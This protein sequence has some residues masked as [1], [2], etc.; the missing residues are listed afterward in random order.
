MLEAKNICKHYQPKKGVSVQAIDHVSLRFPERGMVF[1]LG[2]SGSGK[3]TLLHLLGGLDT[4][5]EGE[6]IFNGISLK[7]FRAQSFDSYRNTCVGFVFQEYNLLSDFSVGANIAIALELQGKKADDAEISR[8]L[9]EVDLDGFGDRKPDELSGGQKQRVAIARALVKNPQIILADEPTGALDAE[10][11]RQVLGTLKELS[12]EKLVILISHEREFAEQY[13]D[14][15]IEMADGKVVRDVEW[16][17]EQPE[18]STLSFRSSAIEIPCGYQLTEADRLRINEYLER[19]K[20]DATMMQSDDM[21]GFQQTDETRIPVPQGEPPELIHSKMPLRRAFHIGCSNLGHKRFRLGM[22]IFLSVVAFSMFALADTFH[23]YEH[24]RV[25]TDSLLQYETEYVTVHKAE[26]CSDSLS[27]Y[28]STEG[29]LLSDDDLTVIRNDTGVAMTG[30]YLPPSSNLSYSMHFDYTAL[31]SNNTVLMSEFCGFTEISEEVLAE[32]GCSLIAGSIPDGNKNEIALSL[33]ACEPFLKAGYAPVI[34]DDNGFVSY[35][36]WATNE[37]DGK[38]LRVV[39]YSKITAPQDMI[40]KTLLLDKVSYTVTGVVDTHEDTE[41]YQPQRDAEGVVSKSQ[42][43]LNEMLLA[44]F[45]SAVHHSLTG[46]AM[47]GSGKVTQMIEAAPNTYAPRTG[48]GFSMQSNIYADR[49]YAVKPTHYTTMSR[50]ASDEILWLDGERESLAENEVILSVDSIQCVLRNGSTLSLFSA[51]EAITLEK[52]Q[53]LTADIGTLNGSVEIGGV[54]AQR[55]EAVQIVGFIQA[56]SVYHGTMICADAIVKQLIDVDGKYV[57]AFGAMPDSRD[58]LEEFVRYCYRD[59]VDVQMRYELNHA[60][61]YELDKID[62]VFQLFY[63]VLSVFSGGFAIFAMLLM[64]GFITRSIQHRE[65]EIGILRAIGARSNDVLHIFLSET[66]MIAL[67]N[68]LLSMS[69]CSGC[70]M[71]VN[72]AVRRYYHIV[73]QLLHFDTRQV[74]LLLAVSMLS[75]WLAGFVP[76]SS[77]AAKK[78]LDAICGR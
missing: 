52:L 72:Y 30:I 68:F 37:E 46:C 45:D 23:S 75:A 41:R 59:D 39:D 44:E 73:V 6:I 60:V 43:L 76:A 25:C 50:I 21:R 48:C 16:I 2:K 35:N 7:K 62:T 24:I 17:T 64:A 38:S 77:I 42:R 13:A 11:G 58:A 3:S 34:C 27:A 63:T 71:L 53:K 55:M 47:V 32:M 29:V 1:L 26:K 4:C 74:L 15:I 61:T 28:W 22:T 54:N 69:F 33:V 78:P 12:A 10:T 20:N 31:P 66:L 8:I 51:N 14:R 56:D 9:H 36:Q 5:D 70:V 57:N 67:M 40:G 18:E 65:H 49:N 19:Q